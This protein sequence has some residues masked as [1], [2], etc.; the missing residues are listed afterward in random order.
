MPLYK[1]SND[2]EIDLAEITE[3]TYENHGTTQTLKYI[4]QLDECTN[5]LAS[6]DG[7]Y[8]E[9]S[10]IHPQL[11]IKHCQHHYIFGVMRSSQPML[12][13]AILHER[14]KLIERVKK[15]LK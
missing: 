1:L 15:R 5:N 6:G 3:Y 14:M 4:D 11:R 12:V 9:E 2:A 8:K 13:V 10:K 7:H